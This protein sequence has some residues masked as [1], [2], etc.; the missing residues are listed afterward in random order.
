MALAFINNNAC[1][2]KHFLG[3]MNRVRRVEKRHWY[4][5]HDC[6]VNWIFFFSTLIHFCERK[7]INFLKYQKNLSGKEIIFPLKSCYRYNDEFFPLVQV[8]VQTFNFIRCQCLDFQFTSGP[9]TS[10]PYKVI[11]LNNLY[12]ALN[13]IV[14]F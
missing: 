4:P 1:T 5:L 13:K 14:K 10:W 3:G 7:N 8:Q 12:P 6:K 9:M 2:Q 11:D